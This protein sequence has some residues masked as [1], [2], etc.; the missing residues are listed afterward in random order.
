[1]TSWIIK[2]LLDENQVKQIRSFV[3]NLEKLIKIFY[4]LANTNEYNTKQKL[5]SGALGANY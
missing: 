3:E 1:M 2:K 5:L 4:L